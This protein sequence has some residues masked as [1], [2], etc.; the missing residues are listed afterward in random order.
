MIGFLSLAIPLCWLKAQRI[1][2]IIAGQRGSAQRLV[3][4]ECLMRGQSNWM[5]TSST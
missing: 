2:I 5:K 4:K 3:P 1:N